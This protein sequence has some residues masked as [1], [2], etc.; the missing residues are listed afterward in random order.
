MSIVKNRTS[1]I[2][3]IVLLITAGAG[4][5]QV[6]E[7][8]HHHP[9]V[10]A[11]EQQVADGHLSYEEG[12]LK[13][14]EIVFNKESP[15]VH[16]LDEAIETTQRH[17]YRCVTPLFAELENN[18]D[19]LSDEVIASISESVSLSENELSKYY[20][21]PDSIFKIHYAID[22]KNSVPLKDENDSGVPDY[23]EAA[24][25]A[26]D[27]T[28]EKLVEDVGFK[29]PRNVDT[30]L[31]N[32]NIGNLEHLDSSFG[33]V[34][35]LARSSYPNTT[36]I[37]VRNAYH[38]Q[39]NFPPNDHENDEIG[40]LKV[41]I[42]HEIFHAI[43]Y[44]YTNWHG[45]TGELEWI[46]MDAVMMEEVVFPNVNDYHN[47]LT[48]FSSIFKSPIVSTPGSYTH[49]TW[50]LYY[51]QFYGID[52]WREVW[53]KLGK[54]DNYDLSHPEVKELIKSSSELQRDRVRN[55]LWHLS[56]GDFA[57]D[58][59]GFKESS[60]YP[61]ALRADTADF[62]PSGFRPTL[63]YEDYIFDY[64]AKYF[65][66]QP[67]LDDSGTLRIGLFDDGHDLSIGILGVRFSGEVEEMII[68]S[69]N[70]EPDLI[71]TGFDVS[72][73][74]D[75]RIVVSGNTMGAQ[76][77]FRFVVGAG[78]GVESIAYGDFDENEI[79]DEN[80]VASLLNMVVND[81]NPYSTEQFRGDVS[82]SEELT[83]YDG[84]LILQKIDGNI[85]SFPVDKSGTGFGPEADEFEQPSPP[86]AKAV[87]YI[88]SSNIPNVDW[89]LQLLEDNPQ[90]QNPIDIGLTIDIDENVEVKDF[91]SLF[92]KFEIPEWLELR[93]LEKLSV[94]HNAVSDYHQVDDTL[95][96][97]VSGREAFQEDDLLTLSFEPLDYGTTEI[98]LLSARLDEFAPH[99]SPATT[100]SFEID[101]SVVVGIDEEDE[102][103]EQLTLHSNYPNPFNPVT[104]IEFDLPESGETR[105]SVYDVNGREITT[106]V[107]QQLEAGTHQYSFDGSGLASGVYI[108]R[109]EAP[110]GVR[111][112]KMTLVK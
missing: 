63:G 49:A 102:I 108:Y 69:T 73:F 88:D 7:H 68:H 64:G 20:V 48:N 62:L 94:L 9:A 46:E 71:D 51:V 27:Y 34:Y 110:T 43:Q 41:T 97:A 2:T 67:D 81:N 112:D 76:G 24:A 75:F 84:S 92:L 61:N 44:Q 5:G 87:N 18:K 12:L 38:S 55:H 105:L 23:V 56:S 11:V 95:R 36:E 66:Y 106:L 26:A 83:A 107:D 98:K 101:E 39:Y 52:F 33:K 17:D 45:P 72:E 28:Y 29:D 32:I 8:H 53:E 89:D 31:Y 70:N 57:L 42:A 104:T 40:A 86:L 6:H 59:Y 58:T 37:E 65:A 99:P 111:T 54:D 47:Y 90:T 21:S 14:F 16:L 35:G 96:V 25:S 30:V 79:I 82:G 91:Y 60:E 93:E 109:L 19:K 85:D 78:D 103:P 4:F 77:R 15:D 100:G 10:E 74:K 3:I 50:F 1:L 13:R 80:D 22:G